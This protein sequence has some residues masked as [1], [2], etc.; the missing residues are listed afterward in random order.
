MI[1]PQHIVLDLDNTLIFSTENMLSER[2]FDHMI[3]NLYIYHRPYLEDFF[4][5]CF[6]N[7]RSVN[8]WSHGD[9]EW[10]NVNLIQI[11]PQCYW[12]RLGFVHH[13][14]Y[15]KELGSNWIK[16]MHQV[17]DDPY[18]VEK[19]LGIRNTIIIDDI[20]SNHVLHPLNLL[21][22]NPYR[23]DQNDLTLRNIMTQLSQIRYLSDIRDHITMPLKSLR[24]L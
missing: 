9:W 3:D 2:P 16:D 7:Y 1:Y 4:E 12:N 10:I 13:R 19:G 17:W 24:K 21:S 15:H 14:E 18:Y 22:V 11:L 6:E 23:G 5:F 8:I 20:P